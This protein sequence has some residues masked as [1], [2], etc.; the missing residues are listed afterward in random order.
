MKRQRFK[1]EC[2]IE[3]SP[4]DGETI[5]TARVEKEILDGI[6]YEL[7]YLKPLA[8]EN[9]KTEEMETETEGA[10]SLQERYGIELFSEYV[11][12]STFPNS[13]TKRNVWRC[14]LERNGGSYD[15]DYHKGIGLPNT[16]PTVE[17]VMEGLQKTDVGDFDEFVDNYGYND[18]SP[19]AAY[20]VYKAVC[21]EYRNMRRLFTYEELCELDRME[22]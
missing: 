3:L 15:F 5:T 18:E 13:D 14:R 8:I 12:R 6:K 20:K 17:E 2:E 7:D 22:Y 4:L 1:F 11:G 9:I 21:D 19:K 10:K 16:K